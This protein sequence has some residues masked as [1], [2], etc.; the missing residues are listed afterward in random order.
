MPV[1]VKLAGGDAVFYG[2]TAV[3]EV[4]PERISGHRTTWRLG[5]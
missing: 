2:A 3:H 4:A 1:P 5:H